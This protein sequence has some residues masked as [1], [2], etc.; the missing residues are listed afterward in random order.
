M[1]N[2]RLES[3]KLERVTVT[4][5]LGVRFFD[6]ATNT[7]VADGLLVEAYPVGNP[8]RR[9]TAVPNRSGVW[10]FHG[11]PGLRE[12]EYSADDEKRW[13]PEPPKRR[14]VVEVIDSQNRFLPS[15]FAIDAPA[16]A[17]SVGDEFASPLVPAL[18]TVSLF[19]SPGRPVPG[20]FALV[21]AQLFEDGGGTPAAWTLVEI[22]ISVLDRTV[23][24]QGIADREGRLAL[25]FPYPE[26]GNVSIGSPVGAGPQLLSQQS[27]TLTF[28][29]WHT[30]DSQPADFVDVDRVL[31]LAV[32]APDHLW[33]YGSPLIPF[34]GA[35]LVFGRE[36]VVPVRLAGDLRPRALFI[37]PA[38]SPF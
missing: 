8:A 28:R 23:T 21:R 13:T 1:T 16:R 2:L 32:R 17:L 7:I 25:I 3:L 26:P 5:P 14:F 12:F 33:D 29:A 18:R 15:R 27:W 6:T 10:A 38:G 36:L 34:T 22:R 35:D 37:T 9:V 30:F 31:G 24:A 20:G 11:L 19:S 4:C